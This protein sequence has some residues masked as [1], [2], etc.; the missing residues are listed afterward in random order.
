MIGSHLEI[1]KRQSFTFI[2]SSHFGRLFRKNAEF[3]EAKIFDGLFL[4][5]SV[6]FRG[7]HRLPGASLIIN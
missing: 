2:L 3:R 5:F 4:D 7:T 1:L 6:K